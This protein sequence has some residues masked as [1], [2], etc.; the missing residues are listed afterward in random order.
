MQEHTQ[1]QYQWQQRWQQ[2]FVQAPRASLPANL[3]NP[4]NPLMPN[5]TAAPANPITGQIIVLTGDGLGKSNTAFGMG[6]AVLAQNRPLAVVQ[7]LDT[8]QNSPARQ[9]LGQHAQCVFETFGRGCTWDTHE[10]KHDTDLTRQAWA[11][12][13]EKM[14][15]PDISM[16]ILDDINLMLRHSYLNIDAVLHG[17]QQRPP[18]L[19]VVLTGRHAPFELIDMA[20]I[21]IEMRDMKA[22]AP[23]NGKSPLRQPFPK[24]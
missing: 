1:R 7:F 18:A 6:M 20:D 22:P 3:D 24:R 23:S 19:T 15:H 12:A 13:T 11:Y 10:R 5:P 14:Q 4:D 9:F 16:V 8:P 2:K 17:L 21:C